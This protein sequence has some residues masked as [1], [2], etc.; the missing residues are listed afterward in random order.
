MN[1]ASCGFD[2]FAKIVK[3]V[4]QCAF[5]LLVQ[6]ISVCEGRGRATGL[7]NILSVLSQALMI[8]GVYRTDMTWILGFVRM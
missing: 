7:F 3:D 4:S 8:A 6:R 1:N 5:D 2:L